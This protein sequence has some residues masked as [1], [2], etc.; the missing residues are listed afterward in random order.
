MSYSFPASREQ[1]L[2]NLQD[3]GSNTLMPIE[4]GWGMLLP[5]G[6][7]LIL[8]ETVPQKSITSRLDLAVVVVDY[9]TIPVSLTFPS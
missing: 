7:K 3:I 4:T 5:S 1:T 2:A 9:L 8:S 6:G